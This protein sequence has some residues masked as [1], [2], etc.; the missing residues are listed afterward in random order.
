MKQYLTKFSTRA[1]YEAE[2]SNLDFPN[3]SYISG[4]DELVYAESGSSPTHDYS[5]DYFTI[6]AIDDNLSFEIGD[7][8][9]S[10]VYYSS[11]GGDTWT[12]GNM[13]TMNAGDKVMLKNNSYITQS[14]PGVNGI[15]WE[16]NGGR[17]NVMGNIMS[18]F[19]DDDFVGQEDGLAGC[20]SVFYEM[21]LNSGVVDASNLVLP[22]TLLE[23]ATSCYASMFKGCTLLEKAPTILPATTLAEN[24]YENMFSGCTSLTTAPELPATTL[25]ENCY[26]GMFSDCTSLNYIKMLATDISATGCLYGWVNGV[27]AS[28]TFVKNASMT[29]LPTGDNGI[30]S[31]WT[32]IDA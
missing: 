27:A 18:L 1:A 31:G 17:Y 32:V 6:E 3:V 14:T 19:F 16:Q 25:A 23:E 21:F 7:G 20:D 26:C 24:C 13:F 15:I 10:S 2:L 29:T 22:A 5:L 8:V 28:G 9:N 30:P 11:D 4:D 12:N